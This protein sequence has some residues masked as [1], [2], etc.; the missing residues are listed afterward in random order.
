MGARHLEACQKIEVSN[1]TLKEIQEPTVYGGKKLWLKFNNP[2]I[3]LKREIV[4]RN[5][6]SIWGF[7]SLACF[8]HESVYNV[9]LSHFCVTNRLRYRSLKVL[10][11]VPK[12]KFQ[13]RALTKGIQGS[14][15]TMIDGELRNTYNTLISNFW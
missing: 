1:W 2:L 6:K 7:L 5:F 13:K 12:F 3:I 14:D 15:K 9:A 8:S 4:K 11:P 10:L